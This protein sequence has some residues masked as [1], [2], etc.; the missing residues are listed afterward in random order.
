MNTIDIL[1]QFRI[2]GYALFD[3]GVSFLGIYLLSPL[4]SKLFLKLR[5][6]ITKRSWLFFTL[7]LSILVHIIVGNITPM[8]KNFIDVHGHYFLK[9]IILGLFILGIKGTKIMSK[10]SNTTPIQPRGLR[11]LPNKSKT[12]IYYINKFSSICLGL[13]LTASI[14]RLWCTFLASFA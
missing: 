14:P 11:G 7:P 13:T 12:A 5:I 10:K 6:K 2:G 9:I 1:R 8:T 4:L 3:L